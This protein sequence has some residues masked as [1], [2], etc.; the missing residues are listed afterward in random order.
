MWSTLHILPKDK[1]MVN[2]SVSIVKDT[3]ILLITVLKKF[4]IMVSNRA[5]HERLSYSTSKMDR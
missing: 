2:L 1:E 3:V 4:A 5:F